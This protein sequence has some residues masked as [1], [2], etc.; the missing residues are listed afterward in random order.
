MTQ[1][2]IYKL[3]VE[4]RYCSW[5][6][7]LLENKHFENPVFL[8]VDP[9]DNKLFSGDTFSIDCNNKLQLIEKLLIQMNIEILESINIVNLIDEN[10]L[11]SSQN[12]LNALFNVLLSQVSLGTSF[13][14]NGP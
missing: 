3:E 13:L 2:Q 9:L 8:K 11:V 1:N 12:K 14:S 10:N 5:S 6:T 4:N 7:Y